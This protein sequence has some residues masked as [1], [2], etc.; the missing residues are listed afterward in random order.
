MPAIGSAWDLRAVLLARGGERYTGEPVSH[1]EHALQCADFAERAGGA[2]PLVVAALLHDIGHLLSHFSGTPSAAGIDD[3]HELLGAACLD[4]LFGAEVSEPV[5]L[6]VAAK[7]YLAAD[8]AYWRALSEDSLR[9]LALQGGEMSV[10]ERT[11]FEQSPHAAAALRLR[12]WDD[13]AKRPGRATPRLEHFWPRVEQLVLRCAAV[14]EAH[15][16]PSAKATHTA[17]SSV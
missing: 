1:L 15:N 13:A 4:P 7:R 3:R 16:H 14:S 11:A 6:H 8:P 12:R 5:R 10:E 2:E 17:Q 9:S